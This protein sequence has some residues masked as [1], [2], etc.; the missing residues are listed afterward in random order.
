[1]ID[2]LKFLLLDKYWSVTENNTELKDS[3]SGMKVKITGVPKNGLVVNVPPGGK[4]HIGVVEAKIDYKKSCDQLIFIPC[5]NHVDVYFVEMK[6]SLNPVDKS[7]PDK[8][9]KQILCTIPTLQYLVSMA[10]IHYG[11][12]Q[13]INQYYTVIG[14]KMSSRLD[15]QGVRYNHPQSVS[16]ENRN[17]KVILSPTIPFAMLK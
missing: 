16:Y 12:D 7:V 10:N 9:C 15:K 17:F 4:S 5:N 13:K 6:K 11:N 2:S 1:M 8:A 14:E 3:Q